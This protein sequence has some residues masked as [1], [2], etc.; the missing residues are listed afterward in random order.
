[1][2][3]RHIKT[4]VFFTLLAILFLGWLAVFFL[5]DPAELIAWFGVTNSYFIAFLLSLIGALAT[6]TTVSTYPAIYTMAAG[7]LDPVLLVLVSTVGLSIGDF[8]FIALGISARS[9]VSPATAQ[10]IERLLHWLYKQPTFVIQIILFL[11]VG[12]TPIANNLL[13]APL[14]LTNFPTRKMVLPIVLGNMTLPALAII[15]GVMHRAPL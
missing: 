1:M 15:V 14:A 9:V 3:R 5:Y 7:N 12:F 11:W 10:R 13:T 6:L 4:F 8:L 2:K